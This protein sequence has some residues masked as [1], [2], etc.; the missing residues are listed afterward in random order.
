[1]RFERQR[2]GMAVLEEQ[3]QEQEELRALKDQERRMVPFFSPLSLSYLAMYIKA[4]IH[5]ISQLTESFVE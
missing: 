5:M 2:A 4:P 1:M 3:L